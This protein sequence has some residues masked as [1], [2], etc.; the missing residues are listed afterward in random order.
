MS[1][2]FLAV[3]GGVSLAESF[4]AMSLCAPSSWKA[5]LDPSCSSDSET[6]CSPGSP[7]GMTFAPLTG[8]PG[9]DGL[10]SLRA[11]SPARTSVPRERALES[12]APGL[13][14]GLSSPES[15]VRSSLLSASSKIPLFSEPEGW[16]SCW[17][18]LPQWGSMRNGGLSGRTKPAHLT[19][20]TGCGFL[21]TP[22][23]TIGTNGGPNQRD[24][25]GRPGMQMAAMMWPT[26]TAMNNTGGPALCKW[27][28]SGARAKL[29][30]MVTPEELNG[31]LNPEWVCW[32]M[33]WP[34]GWT[35]LK[36]LETAKFRKWLHSHSEPSTAA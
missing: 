27:G 20:A 5:T 35:D 21:L 15:L 18:T 4:A 16:R 34:I 10:T 36:P 30:T 24:S 31:A 17:K 25:S 6:G 2:T 1:Y 19:S 8:T 14:S 29:R 11:A 28:G 13:A 9:A 12:L 7:C 22:L 32:L 26:P 23:A 33:G 3:T